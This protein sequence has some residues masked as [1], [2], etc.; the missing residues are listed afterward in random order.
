MDYTADGKE[1]NIADL[2]T[3][4]T[5]MEKINSLVYPAVLERVKGS[6]DKMIAALNNKRRV[7]TKDSIIPVGATVML[8]DP[9]RENK[10]APKYIGP[11]TVTYRTRNGNYQ[12]KDGTGFILDRRAPPDQLKL[13]SKSKRQ[14]DYEI[15]YVVDYIIDHRGEPGTYEYY[16]KFKGYDIPEWTPQQ[17]FD[18]TQCIRDYWKSKERS[19]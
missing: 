5:H 9:D 4:N 2:P 3:W 6:K 7:L 18:D 8:N 12:L 15:N 17:N 11:Y 19:E 16:T 13:V 14:R 1:V 10:F